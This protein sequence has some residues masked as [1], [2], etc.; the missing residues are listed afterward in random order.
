MTDL[1]WPKIGAA[2]AFFVALAL[3][4]LASTDYILSVMTLV[5]QYAYLGQAWNI[6]MGFAG[7]LSLGHALYLGLGGYATG[8]LLATYGVTP[9]V[10]MVAGLV[11]ATAAGAVV[12]WLGFRFAVRGI[13][14]ALLTIAFAEFL[15]I[16]FNHWSLVGGSGGLYLGAPDPTR[17]PLAALRGG[18][19]LWYYVFLTLVVASCVLA[20]LLLRRRVGY[21]WRAIRE[22]EDAARALGVQPFRL[23]VLAVAVSAAMTS[24]GGGLFAL[25]NGSLFPDTVFGVAMSIDILAGPV[26]GGLGSIAGPL[27][28]AALILPLAEVANAIAER[29]GLFGLNA[30]V[31]GTAILA[32]VLFMPHGLWPWLTSMAARMRRA[33]SRP[34]PPSRS[35]A[36]MDTAPHPM[37]R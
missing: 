8:V 24:I 21:L 11:I 14:F 33:A 28:G 32:I 27:V 4:P 35:G 26:I 1:S 29:M 12:G 15:R 7:Q 10:G 19:V 16:L 22:N 3:L 13:Y 34:E 20:A 5:F 25:R 37:A 18:A 23:K 2:A 31:N 6:M 36:G 9:W 30:L 17:H